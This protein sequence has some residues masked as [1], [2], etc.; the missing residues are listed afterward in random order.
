MQ[1]RTGSAQDPASRR[2][3]IDVADVMLAEH[4]I[5]RCQISPYELL[6]VCRHFVAPLL[7]LFLHGR[8][9][10]GWR[11]IGTA[12][13]LIEQIVDLLQEHR[14]PSAIVLPAAGELE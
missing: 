2:L 13:E 6:K 11:K 14:R 3:E 8:L 12:I 7:Q 5:E 1:G 9:L 10:R 4:G